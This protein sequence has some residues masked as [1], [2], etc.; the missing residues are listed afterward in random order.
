MIED[1]DFAGHALSVV[2]EGPPEES[3]SYDP[4]EPRDIHS[5]HDWIERLRWMEC[6]RCGVRDHWPAGEKRC[7]VPHGK[8]AIVTQIEAEEWLHADL[9]E[10]FLW[11]TRRKHPAKLP[12][13]DEWAAN[14]YEWRME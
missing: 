12:S 2:G 6:A 8:A 9:L 14:F 7:K 11:W 5:S 10:F 3:S 13:V 1:I 4:E